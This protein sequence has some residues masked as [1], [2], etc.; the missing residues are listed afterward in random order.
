M[1]ISHPLLPLLS[2][3]R[4]RGPGRVRIKLAALIGKYGYLVEAEN[5]RSAEGWY[6]INQKYDDTTLTWEVWV[7]AGTAERQDPHGNP[8]PYTA[9]D[10][11]VNLGS[12]DTMS[13]CI[14][15]GIDID[16]KTDYFSVIWVDAKS[17]KNGY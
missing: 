7:K 14:K 17:P 11:D 2:K 6:R 16:P 5:L 10:Q 4:N 15:Y 3:V 1:R 9:P 13:E 8:W 12:Y